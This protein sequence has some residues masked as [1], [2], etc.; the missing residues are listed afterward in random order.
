F[1]LDVSVLQFLLLRDGYYHGAL[2]GYFGPRLLAAVRHFQR[3]Y[4]LS[5]DGIAGPQTLASLARRHRSQ[6][7]LPRRTYLVEPGDSLTAVAARFGTTVAGLARA[8]KLDASA[9][10]LIGT[11]LAVPPPRALAA[12]PS[13]VQARLDSWAQRLGVEPDL[14]R[15]LAWM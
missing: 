13:D 7:T 8:N 5:A 3:R 14:V 4:R 11:H 2:D 1:G 15:A 12:T 6:P 10:L 9:V